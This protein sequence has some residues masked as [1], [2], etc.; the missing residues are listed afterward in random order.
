MSRLTDREALLAERA[1]RQRLAP[2]ARVRSQRGLLSLIRALQP[3]SPR[4]FTFPGTPP[5]LAPRVTFDDLPASEDLR[6]RG[7]IVKGRFAGGNVA[8][9]V[10]EDLPLYAAA[11]RRP[12]GRLSPEARAVLDLLESEGPTV[13]SDMKALLE[14]PGRRLSAALIELQR[15]FLVTELQYETEWDN[16][17]ALVADEYP[18][19]AADAID[20][21]TAI[22]EVL[23]RALHALAFATLEQ[24]A[25]R[26][27]FGRAATGASVARLAAADRAEPV[28]LAEVGTAWLAPGAAAAAR[29]ARR[30]ETFEAVLDPQDPLVLAHRGE[31]T[32]RYGRG[33]VLAYIVIDGCF[34]GAALGRWGI[35][36][37]DVEDVR[38]DPPYDAQPE[39]RPAIIEGLQTFFPPPEQRIL[40]WMGKPF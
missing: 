32:R 1:R 22:D 36:P 20:R 40:R 14:A 39:R 11:Y 29:R 8:Y 10:T 7:A 2:S 24:L 16:A 27:G 37:F 18:A 21:N 3:V 33:G 17:W 28:A 19:V 15:A 25:D 34:A 4:S 31:L 35:N 5:Q 6:R 12:A 9:V 26:T 23:A 30:R 13:R 38:L